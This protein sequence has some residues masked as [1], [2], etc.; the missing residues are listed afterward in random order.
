[1]PSKNQIIY[2]K[3]FN[4]RQGHNLKVVGSNP[5]LD[6]NSTRADISPLAPA[7]VVPLR[8]KYALQERRRRMLHHIVQAALIGPKR[9]RGAQQ[10]VSP[11]V[12]LNL[13]CRP[14][15]KTDRAGIE[16]LHHS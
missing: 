5:T 7:L 14:T 3:S 1:M 13:N 8:Q 11:A 6:L 16:R 12:P 15:T 2:L 9:H 10:N 4:P